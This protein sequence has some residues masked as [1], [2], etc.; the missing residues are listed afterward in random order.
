M[1]TW[2]L[3]TR[4]EKTSGPAGTSVRALWETW[5]DILTVLVRRVAQPHGILCI[6]FGYV[7]VARFATS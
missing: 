2:Y 4:P 3:T 5:Y 1:S 6:I 7:K